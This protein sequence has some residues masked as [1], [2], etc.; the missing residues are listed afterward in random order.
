MLK[1][2]DKLRNKNGFHSIV[3]FFGSFYLSIWN[4]IICYTPSYAIRHFVL[5][6][7]Y[8]VKT[9]KN[10]Y[11]HMGVKFLKPWGVIIGNNVNIQ[12]GSFIDGRG[13]ITIEDNVDITI[14]VKILTQQHNLQDSFYTTESKPVYIS[15]NSVIGSFSLIMPGVSIGKGSVIGAGSVVSKS[16]PEWSIAVGNPCIVK[17]N[18]NQEI[19]YTIGYARP[20]H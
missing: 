16:I 3:T 7:F 20:F 2:L 13:G 12:M 17:K 1:R 4:W 19:N 9:G 15:T 11:I 14:G 8:G 6:N 10:V 18:R 5:R